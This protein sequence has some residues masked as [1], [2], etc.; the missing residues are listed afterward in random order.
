M[1]VE[2]VC[3]PNRRGGKSLSGPD[4]EPSGSAGQAEKS[5]NKLLDGEQMMAL[6]EGDSADVDVDDPATRKRMLK[7]LRSIAFGEN[8]PDVKVTAMKAWFTLKDIA[9]AKD[10]GPGAPKTEEDAIA[11]LADMHKAT[12]FEI[13]M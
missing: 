12:G 9:D 4:E 1:V 13:S 8:H 6:A 11:R 3:K 5:D 2:G 7:E 10:L